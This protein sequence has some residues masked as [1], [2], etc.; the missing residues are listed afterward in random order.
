[1]SER[2]AKYAA[3][4]VVPVSRSRDEIEH[5]LTRYGC[6]DHVVWDIREEAITVGFRCLGWPIRISVRVPARESY[7]R[8]PDHWRDRSDTAVN[9]LY[10]AELRRKWRVLLQRIKTRLEEIADE[11]ASVAEAFHPYL[12]LPGGGTLG[13]QLAPQLEGIL[14]RGEM[15]ELA[16]SL[17]PPILLP[18]PSGQSGK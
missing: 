4:T 16:P 15:P 8:D 6:G 2:R 17:P 12:M 18:P 10:Q 7:R 11:D 1:M 14:A 13:G 9:T 5:T 3:G